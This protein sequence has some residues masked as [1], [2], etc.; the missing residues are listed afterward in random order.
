MD[1]PVI[2]ITRALK[3]ELE[4]RWKT[5]AC[6]FDIKSVKTGEQLEDMTN[7]AAFPVAVIFANQGTPDGGRFDNRYSESVLI[8]LEAY[9]A[10]GANSMETAHKLLWDMIRLVLSAD[11]ELGGVASAVWYRPDDVHEHGWAIFLPERLSPGVVGVGFA[12]SVSYTYEIA[13][14]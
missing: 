5:P 2:G 11:Q 1:S 10:E 6:S 4:S 14:Q 3:T 12:F 7:P 13:V 8:Q 9:T